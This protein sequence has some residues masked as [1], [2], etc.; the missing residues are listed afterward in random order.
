MAKWQD[1]IV[2]IHVGWAIL[3]W[4]SL[5]NALCHVNQLNVS[6]GGHQGVQDYSCGLIL[7]DQKNEIDVNKD[8]ETERGNSFDKDE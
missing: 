2:E 6:N 7:G 8:K 4:P 5:K 3:W 1:H